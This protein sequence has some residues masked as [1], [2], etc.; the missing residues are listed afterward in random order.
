MSELVLVPV[1][2]DG[3]EGP[4]LDGSLRRDL[5]DVWG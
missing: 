4:P 5:E 3:G 1:T 2:P